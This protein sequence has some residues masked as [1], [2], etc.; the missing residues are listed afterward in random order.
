M[1]L[2]LRRS[3]RC[4]GLPQQQP[5]YTRRHVAQRTVRAHAMSNGIAW[6]WNVGDM[7]GLCMCWNSCTTARHVWVVQGCS[8][9][10][11]CTRWYKRNLTGS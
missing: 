4:G 1:C 10:E 7:Q 2:V 8:S 3:C 11:A 6:R 5:R 9:T